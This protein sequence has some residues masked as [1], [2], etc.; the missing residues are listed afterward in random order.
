VICHISATREQTSRLKATAT[1]TDVAGTQVFAR[2]SD[3]VMH[4]QDS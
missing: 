4:T 2:L 1:F 3:I